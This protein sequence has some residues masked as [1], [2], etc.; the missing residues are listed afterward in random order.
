[1]SWVYPLFAPSSIRVYLFRDGVWVWWFLFDFF[2]FSFASFFLLYSL[3]WKRNKTIT[4]CDKKL[5]ER[6]FAKMN[7]KISLPLLILMILFSWFVATLLT[8]CT[9]FRRE[10][11]VPK[12]GEQYFSK[13]RLW[14]LYFDS[15]LKL[16]QPLRYFLCFLND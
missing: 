15:F 14:V 10:K 4:I 13:K 1:M 3:F 11:A 7:A 12:S 9:K 6:H 8:F 16:T 2:S 5:T